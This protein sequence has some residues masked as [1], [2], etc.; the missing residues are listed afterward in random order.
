MPK[1]AGWSGGQLPKGAGWSGGGQLPKG[2]G[3]SGGA[4]APPFSWPYAALLIGGLKQSC[5]IIIGNL[6]EKFG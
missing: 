6:I 2:A 1:G 5:N 3:W 4:I